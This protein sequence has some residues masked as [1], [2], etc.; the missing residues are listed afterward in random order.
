M[1]QGERQLEQC[2]VR[3]WF[4]GRD[5]FAEVEVF[6]ATTHSWVA[7]S[8]F[9]ATTTTHP[10]ITATNFSVTANQSVAISPD[11][12]LFNPSGDNFTIYR[13]LGHGGGS[14][15]LTVGGT[16]EPD[17]Q[18]FKASANW[19]NVQY[20]GGS[21]AGTVSLRVEAYEARQGVASYYFKATTTT[22]PSPAGV[23]DHQ[24]L[25]ATTTSA[26]I[27]GIQGHQGLEHQLMS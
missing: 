27:I 19:S 3:G 8:Y 14:G 7:S 22:S 1:V 4:F 17:G 18:W 21:S 20:V 11:L 10:T 12:T 15:H 25:E 5:R 26:S 13:V 2:P 16:V 6:D 24:R 23:Q 9:K